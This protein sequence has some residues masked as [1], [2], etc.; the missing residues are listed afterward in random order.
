MN[1]SDIV[2]EKPRDPRVPPALSSLKRLRRNSDVPAMKKLVRQ[3]A[4]SLH[5]DGTSAET[6]FT[7]TYVTTTPF[8]SSYASTSRFHRS[9]RLNPIE[10]VSNRAIYDIWSALEIFDRTSMIPGP[11][12]IRAPRKICREIC[13]E[14][15]GNYL[16]MCSE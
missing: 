3:R 2:C 11:K 14:F 1:S 10:N 15:D 5:D 16:F 6:P 8:T 4:S 9:S 7:P 12:T 13:R